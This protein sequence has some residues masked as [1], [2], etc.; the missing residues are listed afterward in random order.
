MNSTLPIITLP[1]QMPLTVFTPF[2]TFSLLDLHPKL[3]T[4]W[5]F[6]VTTQ[7]KNE[8]KSQDAPATRNSSTQFGLSIV[9][10]SDS[11]KIK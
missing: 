7:A 9:L 8:A 5:R 3:T 6:C 10:L 1:L 2:P 4:S 11:N